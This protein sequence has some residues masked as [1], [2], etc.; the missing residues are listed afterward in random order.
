MTDWIVLRRGG[1]TEAESGDELFALNVEQGTCYGFNATATHV[2]KLIERPQRLGE[3]CRTLVEQF[4]VEPDVCER[5]V[6]E[7]L[8]DLEQDGLVGID[9]PAL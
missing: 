4:D 2:W 5:D 6:R 8:R 3:L 9:V 7:L 1:L